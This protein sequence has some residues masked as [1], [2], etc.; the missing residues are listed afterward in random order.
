MEKVT[1]VFVFAV[2]LGVGLAFYVYTVNAD[3][4]DRV[5]PEPAELNA[6]VYFFYSHYCP[7]CR[8]VA[9]YVEEVAKKAEEKGI[10]VTFCCVDEAL[11]Q[12]CAKVAKEIHLSGVPTAVI[13]R[14]G[15]TKLLLGSEEVRMLGKLIGVK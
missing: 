13:Y 12:S 10:N 5:K 2:L 9:P 3:I 15:E 6:S 1:L 14:N 11:Q 8:E 7:H 4:I